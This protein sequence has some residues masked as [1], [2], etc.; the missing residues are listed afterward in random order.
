MTYGSDPKCCR[1]EAV[2]IWENEKILWGKTEEGL[3][4]DSVLF[5]S[6]AQTRKLLTENIN[7]NNPFFSTYNNED[8]VQ[9]DKQI[10]EVKSAYET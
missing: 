6:L 7:L 9:E 1:D 8:C 2:R 5:Q 3:S 4:P 10:N